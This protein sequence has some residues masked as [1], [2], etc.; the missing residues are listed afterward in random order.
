MSGCRA[1]QAAGRLPSGLKSLAHTCT[2][3]PARPL[4]AGDPHRH[5]L[6]RAGRGRLDDHAPVGAAVPDQGHVRAVRAVPLQEPAGRVQV[7]PAARVARPGRPG[8]LGELCDGPGHRVHPVVPGP[9]LVRGDQAAV[10]VRQAGRHGVEDRPFQEPGE[11]C[12][13]VAAD[14]GAVHGRRARLDAA[15]LRPGVHRAQ[16]AG[17]QR[18][19]GGD[20][21]GQGVC[22]GWPAR[23]PRSGSRRRRACP[24]WRCPD[25]L[26]WTRTPRWGCCPRRPA[27]RTGSPPRPVRAGAGGTRPRACRRPTR[28]SRPG[29]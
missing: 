13:Q 8:D 1:N 25:P 20:G 10:L 6:R 24:G 26:G 15:R 22:S 11:P 9:G 12:V 17:P 19:P 28:S 2:V 16:L 14:H 4:A 29:S 23:P 5:L 27:G 21:G 18:L 3:R 7:P